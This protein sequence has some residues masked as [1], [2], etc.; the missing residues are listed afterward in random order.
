[1]LLSDICCAM[2]V[3]SLSVIVP[4]PDKCEKVINWM[5]RLKK[6]PSFKINKHGLDRLRFY[7]ESIG[8]KMC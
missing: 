2:T 4:I 7:V 3:S 1:M 5:Q 6:L 8:P